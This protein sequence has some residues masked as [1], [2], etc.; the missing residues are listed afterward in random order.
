MSI[1]EKR[2]KIKDVAIKDIFGGTRGGANFKSLK[3]TDIETIFNL[4]DS[5]FFDGEIMRKVGESPIEL[6]FRA[7]KRLSGIGGITGYEGGDPA[8]LYID[9][10]PNI[11]NTIFRNSKAG[12]T[13]AAGLGCSD[14]LSCL[15]LIIEHQLVHLIMILW[16]YSTDVSIDTNILKFRKEILKKGD[17]FTPHGE[18]FQCLIK[19]LFGHTKY[20]H[21]LGLI[22]ISVSPP[23]N[24][25]FEAALAKKAKRSPKRVKFMAAYQNWSYSCYL[26]SVMMILFYGISDFWRDVILGSKARG[27]D[28]DLALELKE[29]LFTDYKALTEDGKTIMCSTLRKTLLKK[30]PGLKGKLSWKMYN[31]G[32]AYEIMTSI[33]TD[34]LIDIPV[35]IYRAMEDGTHHPDTVKYAR[36]AMLTFWDYMDPLTDIEEGSDYKVIRWDLIQS[37]IIVFTNGGIPRIRK[38]N[39]KGRE[40][41]KEGKLEVK[42]KKARAFGMTIIDNRYEL[43]GVVMLS[44]VKK[45]GGG[46]HYTSYFKG[47]SDNPLGEDGSSPWYYYNDIGP[48]LNLIQSPPEKIWRDKEGYMP[49]MYFYRKVSSVPIQ[50]MFVSSSKPK[51]E[52]IL[53]EPQSPSLGTPKVLSNKDIEYR[54]I[55][56][57]DGHTLIAIKDKTFTKKLIDKFDDIVKVGAVGKVV[58]TKTKVDHGVTSWRIPTKMMSRVEK[59]I[60]KIIKELK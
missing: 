25:Y 1:E 44:G 54:R 8:I 18:L 17:I 42:I 23:K 22:D 24:I 47:G 56:R 43:I 19:R 37:P 30:E 2:E 59:N 4:Y 26:D 39:K 13:T 41:I 36:E 34:F 38:L 60:A 29:Q 7:S 21:D 55:D 53:E 14:R 51:V 58:V 12:L 27:P 35:Q 20:D 52:K 31:A 40:T 45:E 28:K 6:Q 15:L 10:A 49:S 16:G 33:L 50:S 48:E 9:I 32:A 5:L 46:S 3:G 57:P 11:I